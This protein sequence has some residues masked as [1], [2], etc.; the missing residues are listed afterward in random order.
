MSEVC[1]EQHKPCDKIKTA[2]KKWKEKMRGQ[3][4]A[5]GTGTATA[6]YC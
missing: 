5:T 3:W 4:T 1:K 6:Y 2:L